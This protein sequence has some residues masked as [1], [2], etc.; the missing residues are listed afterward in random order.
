MLSLTGAIGRVNPKVVSNALQGVVL[1]TTVA[2]EYLQHDT[3]LPEENN[4][5]IDQPSLMNML[6]KLS[7]YGGEQVALKFLP[8]FLILLRATFEE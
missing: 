6:M 4:D 8:Q 5:S 1:V 3:L 7:L 2:E